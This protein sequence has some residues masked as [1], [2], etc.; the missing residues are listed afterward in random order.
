MNFSLVVSV[1]TILCELDVIVTAIKKLKYTP[2]KSPPPESGSVIIAP[3]AS[4]NTNVSPESFAVML[5][6]PVI[7]VTGV[8]RPITLAFVVSALPI[9]V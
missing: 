5:V 9:V 7:A 4:L 6:L 3:S 8:L 1:Q 2:V